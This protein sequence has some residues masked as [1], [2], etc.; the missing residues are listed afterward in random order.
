MQLDQMDFHRNS[1]IL[2]PESKKGEK[3]ET[4][5]IAREFQNPRLFCSCSKGK[6]ADC[7][8][9]KKLLSIF[10]Y[11]KE[12]GNGKSPFDLF[13]NSFF[14]HLLN[15][16]IRFQT[17]S[18]ELIKI[19]AE[20][21]DKDNSVRI[22]GV[23]D[24]TLA[25][26]YSEGPDRDRFISRISTE[27]P[28]RY[29]LMNK[30]VEFLQTDHERALI[31]AGHKTERQKNEGSF[32]YRLAYHM[33]REWD[34]DSI[35]IEFAVNDERKPC[36]RFMNESARLIDIIIPQKAVPAILDF[37]QKEKPDLLS[38]YKTEQNCELLFTLCP[39]KQE[40]IDVIPVI[41]SLA[42]KREVNYEID[43]ELVF[44]SVILIPRIRTLCF[45]TLASVKLLATGWG[46]PK[47]IQ[48]SE[49]SAFLEKNESVFSIGSKQETTEIV[50][51]FSNEGADD[52]KRI[53]EPSIVSEFDR[54]ELKPQKVEQELCTLEVIYCAGK[55]RVPLSQ[56]KE[57]QQERNRFLFDGKVICDL[58][59]K[60]IESSLV[61]A[62]KTSKHGTITLSRSALLQFRNTPIS[63]RITGEEK[64]ASK[65]RQMLKFSP[66]KDLKPL[67]D[68]KCILRD[69]QIKG[70]QWLLFLY[71]NSF[72]GLLCDDMG[73][74]KT[75]QVIA[76]LSAIK[77]QRDS[78][79][80]FC[81]VAPTSV[82]S[83]WENLFGMF[84]PSMVIQTYHAPQRKEVL[85]K[86]YDILLTSYGI[87]RNDSEILSSVPF[88]VAVF[89]EVQNLKNKE[90]AAWQCAFEINS[91][92]KIGLT[93]TP[94][95][96]SLSDLRSLLDLTLPGLFENEFPDNEQ[97][98]AALETGSVSLQKARLHRLT[99][100]FIMRRLKGSVLNEL[101]PKIED[102]RQCSLT[103]DQKELYRKAVEEKGKKFI[104][105][106]K[107]DEKPVPYM[108]IFSLLSYLKQV[109]D[110]PALALK[111]VDEYDLYD[112]G[113]WELFTELLEESLNS[114]LKVVV[115]S[116]FLGMIEIIKKYC[117]SISTGYVCLTG[118][119]RNRG[120]VIR[121]F[122]EDTNC[123][124][125]VGSLKAGGVG[126]DL[127]CASVVIHYDRWWNSA[128]EDQATDRVH[129][130]GQRRGVQVFKL[131]TKNSIEERIAS[132]IDRKKDLIENALIEDSPD[133]LK[134][135]SRKELLEILNT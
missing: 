117:E 81:I 103:Y 70:V 77:Q 8:N 109:C 54:I 29:L 76:F 78:N 96:N 42:D 133:T 69:Y 129:R 99:A 35:K 124:V 4:F 100:P 57:A 67:K 116:Q 128:K 2:F 5:L 48:S 13:Q 95:E 73:L 123:K 37:L 125:F 126:I 58:K 105:I 55:N 98:L 83:H 23:K 39:G 22:S 118:S 80:K 64:L 28:S 34:S 53:A 101:P 131:V 49:F 68:V 50:D 85:S 66:L 26:Y 44:E 19:D 74:G 30:A 119:T 43:P 75:I 122:S 27:Y 112:C 97:F 14:L 31:A 17:N 40:N 106:L 46:R 33:Y 45:M 127:V 61:S 7:P 51:L 24:A 9:A 121:K 20:S 59:S 36:L 104:E 82:M 115:F 72:G 3:H 84:S 135:F 111:K 65:I 47:Q 132:I 88:D 12:T 108:H 32:W 63:T 92:I 56:I 41:R 15:N 1:F 94:I 110:H 134:S 91:K 102:I 130:I 62:R 52:Y 18:V 60:K 120:S 113:K 16:V 86:K 10:E 6:Y 11:L 21:A 87:L 25:I 93:G 90:T 79:V 107:D 38:N 71:D 89:D 114:G